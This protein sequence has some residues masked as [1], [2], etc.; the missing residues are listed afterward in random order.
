M[1]ESGEL[2][3]EGL[4]TTWDHHG[5]VNLSPMGARLNALGEGLQLRPFKTSRSYTNLM[6]TSSGVFHITDDVH[7]IARAAIGEVHPM[8]EL[9]MITGTTAYRLNDTCRW[10]LVALDA[11]EQE[12]PRATPE[13]TIQQS[14]RVRDFAGFNRAKHA[15]I[16]AA[17]LATRVGIL[18]D[19]EIR[20]QLT[21]LEPWITKTGGIPERDAFALLKHTVG[22]KMKN[23]DSLRDQ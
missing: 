11:A 3:I 8:P 17:I 22:E 12:G 6:E 20:H 16:E 10:Y 19:D 9:S 2:I 15:V 4:L 5:C 1:A 18:P 7:L 13:M 23:N 21:V 14:G